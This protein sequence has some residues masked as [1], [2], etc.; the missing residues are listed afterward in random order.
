MGIFK[1]WGSIIYG[2]EESI[3]FCSLFVAWSQ[4]YRSVM[5]ISE[6]YH[7]PVSLQLL[8]YP[9]LFT[10]S[11]VPVYLY[12]FPHLQPRVKNSTSKFV[13]DRKTFFYFWC[14]LED[15]TVA[16]EHRHPLLCRINESWV[17]HLPSH[18]LKIPFTLWF[19]CL[20]WS[21]TVKIFQYRLLKEVVQNLF[22]NR[23]LAWMYNDFSFRLSR[24]L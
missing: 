23:L 6:W 5:F 3:E 14:L 12:F 10:S 13:T 15:L 18:K 4:E 16:L 17:E 19:C 7:T 1:L 22:Q 9:R 20:C 8:E 2:L 21:P 24:S 11:A